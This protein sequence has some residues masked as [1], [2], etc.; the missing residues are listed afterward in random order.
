MSRSEFGRERVAIEPRKESQRNAPT[1]AS[2]L[3]GFGACTIVSGSSG[4]L[5]RFRWC[6]QPSR[7]LA[8]HHVCGAFTRSRRRLLQLQPRL[9]GA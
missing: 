6:R 1:A 8:R 9:A 3:D 5:R 2:G 7:C 4:S